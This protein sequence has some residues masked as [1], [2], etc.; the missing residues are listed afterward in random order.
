MKQLDEVS[1]DD[2]P[3][4]EVPQDD[5]PHDEVPHDEVSQQSDELEQQSDEL[6]ES[7]HKQPHK[8]LEAF[9]KYSIASRI[10]PSASPKQ[11][12]ST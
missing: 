10:I 3:H 1:Q 8:R 4:D 5:V 7:S 12:S 11:H 9:S 6:H 2:V